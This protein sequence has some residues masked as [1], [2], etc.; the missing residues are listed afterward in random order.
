MTQLLMVI[1]N[2]PDIATAKALAIKVVE[3]KAAACANVLAS[4]TSVY[5]WKG[6]VESVTEIPV[7]M[8]TTLNAYPRLETLIHSEHPYELPEIIAVPLSKALPEYM[9][10]V[11]AETQL[12]EE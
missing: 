10:W 8:K 5:S 11:D 6:K 4:C 7:W 12:N 2:M 1:T 3:Q 9:K